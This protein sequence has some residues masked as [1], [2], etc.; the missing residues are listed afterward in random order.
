MVA[1]AHNGLRYTA[2]RFREVIRRELEPT[3]RLA[4]PVVLA[5]LGWMAM[6]IV[7]T[8]MVGRL[9]PEAIGAVGIGS[10]LFLALAIFGLGLL[11]GL[12]TLVSHAF[13]AERLDECH[14]WLVH[15][16]YL[17]LILTVPLTLVAVVG[18]L[19][20]PLWGVHPDVLRL[21]RPYLSIV[22]LSILPLLLYAAFRR[23]LQAM[24]LVTPIMFALVSANVVNLVCNWLLIFGNLG[25]PALGVDGAGWATCA[26]R[27]Y[28]AGI[29][30]VA[31]VLH[32]RKEQ[33]GLAQTS[34]AFDWKRIRRILHIGTPAAMQ[35]TLELGVFATATVL[36]GRLEP[37]FLAAH[38]IALNVASFTFMV[39]LGLSSA[40]AV[41]V[42]Q[43]YGRRDPAGAAG[44]GWTAIVVGMAFMSFAALSFVLLP[45]ML[46]RVFTPDRGVIAIGVRLLLVAAVFQLFDG[47]QGVTTG[48]LRGVGNT[49]TPMLS[50]LAGHWLFGLPL[51]YTLCFIL[52]WG[53]IGLWIGL[54]TGLVIVALVLLRTWWVRSR[55]LALELAPEVAI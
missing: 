48:V 37:E 17:S 4:G 13:G 42:G 38:Q 35:V 40:A 25:A 52:G 47:I 9:S 2:V 44:A 54:S 51:G 29:L 3:L 33:I 23:Y 24:G 15:G 45:T 53:V 43:A 55:A 26:S 20:L 49:R 12:D 28:M 8:I 27:V 36:A 11:L 32:E 34:L 46:L 50:N 14:R 7:D 21:T 39:P 6:G 1:M 5:E 16:V 10:S 31:I 22:T 19:T 41:R 18:I 30:L